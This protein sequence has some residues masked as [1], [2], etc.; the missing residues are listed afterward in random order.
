MEKS[1]NVMKPVLVEYP[2]VDLWVIAFKT[3]EAIGGFD[4]AVSGKKFY[5][6]FIPTTP[7]PTSGFLILMPEEKIKPLDV[8]FESAIKMV[9]TA[10]MVK[11]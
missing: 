8:P 7:N 10:G 11:E 2:S 5:T 4:P 6:I 3:G 9:F 1:A